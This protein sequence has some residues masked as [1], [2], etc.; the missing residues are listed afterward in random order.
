MKK[1]LILAGLLLVGYANAQAQVDQNEGKVSINTTEPKATFQ[2]NPFKTDGSTLEG[3]LVPRLA[4]ASLVEMKKITELQEATLVYVTDEVATADNA[5]FVGTGK[6]F[7]Y[8]NGTDKKWTKLGA[9]AS[10]TASGEV[11]IGRTGLTSSSTFDWT[12]KQDNNVNDKDGLANFYEFT[13]D[14]GLM[15]L[16]NPADY[17]NKIISVRNNTGGTLQFEGGDGIGRP[18]GVGSLVATGAVMIWSDGTKW[19]NIAGRQ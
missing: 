15:R 19:H 13:Q 3:V 16:P 12:K 2:V 7:Y 9:G 10:S 5:D 14:S 11:F 8:Y 1:T 17:K 18:A 4:K 6:G